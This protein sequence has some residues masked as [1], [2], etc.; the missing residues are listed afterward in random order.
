MLRRL[1]VSQWLLEASM[2]IE[3]FLFASPA[4]LP[5]CTT[6]GPSDSLRKSLSCTSIMMEW[7][8]QVVG[9]S[10]FQ[11]WSRATRAQRRRWMPAPLHQCW[12][13][14]HLWPGPTEAGSSGAAWHWQWGRC[15][16]PFWGLISLQHA[17]GFVNSCIVF[18]NEDLFAHSICKKDLASQRQ[19][20]MMAL[21]KRWFGFKFRRFKK[22]WRAFANRAKAHLLDW[23]WQSLAYKVQRSDHWAKNANLTCW[24]VNHCDYNLKV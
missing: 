7:C 12:R 4:F 13:S 15:A 5:A 14:R 17:S 21:G 2:R 11:W 22:L 23:N 24:D 1:M 10:N 3:K 19:S 6:S 9:W 8:V 16:Y 20:M 18:V